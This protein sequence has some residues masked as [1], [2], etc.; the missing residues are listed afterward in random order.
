M[1]IVAVIIRTNHPF[2]NRP[3]RF[4]V[5]IPWDFLSLKLWTSLLFSL[6][7]SRTIL[8]ICLLPADVK[9]AFFSCDR[10]CIDF[11]RFGHEK[12]WSFDFREPISAMSSGYSVYSSW[13]WTA[14][15][16]F[17]ALAGPATATF[18]WVP[19]PYYY[20]YQQKIQL[21][22]SLAALKVSQDFG[23][24]IDCRDR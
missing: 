3:L 1:H 21:D 20:D 2:I 15:S 8:A 7:L 18:I 23:Q 6:D 14:L 12:D 5:A 4:P 19:S 24:V 13:L 16:S 17:S 9:L 11:V 22:L 10:P